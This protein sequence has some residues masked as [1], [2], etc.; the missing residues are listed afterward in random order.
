MKIEEVVILVIE[1]LEK[2]D[3]DYMIAGSFASSLHG[4]P[5][6][7]FDA[8]IVI[9]ADSQKIKEFISEIKED[10]Y[11]DVDMAVETVEKGGMFNIIHLDTGFKIDLIVKK[12]G[13]YF[14]REF[15]RRRLYKLGGKECFFASPEDT[16]LSKL[17]WSK[18]AASERQFGDA[19]GV[20]KVQKE[21][22]DYNYLKKYANN[23]SISELL[24]K[25]LKE[26]EE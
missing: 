5:R 14:E 20:A 13:E 21:N 25:L 12:K 22:L 4:I 23:L 17:L 10:F 11:A 26:I 3:I 24:K 1:T 6:T 9:S 8:D 19:L 7:T 15:E 2:C 16:I 18:M